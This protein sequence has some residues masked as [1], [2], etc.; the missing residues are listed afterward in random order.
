M[1][2]LEEEDVVTAD[3]LYQPME[4]LKSDPMFRHR[5]KPHLFL[6]SEKFD[7]PICFFERIL[8]FRPRGER[9]IPGA[10]TLARETREMCLEVLHLVDIHQD[11]DM[12]AHS[13]LT[14]ADEVGSTLG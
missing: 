1:I 13:Q 12:I 5:N 11:R 4:T 7:E 3:L 14:D 2:L 8:P 9:E 6:E 10:M